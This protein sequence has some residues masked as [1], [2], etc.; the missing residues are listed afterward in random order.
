MKNT[1]RAVAPLLVSLVLMPSA[2]SAQDFGL[3]DVLAR[4]SSYVE[5]FRTRLAGIVAEEKYVQD[6]QSNSDILVSSVRAMPHR[7]LKSDLLLVRPAETDMYLEFRDVFE[8][9]GKPVR[10]RQE[11]LSK[12]FLDPS[13][14][15]SDQI[16][17]IMTASAR[18][19]IGNI[20]RNINTPTLALLFLYR[21]FQPRFAFRRASDTLPALA[22]NQAREAETDRHFVVPRNAFVVEYREVRKGTVIRRITGGGDQPSRGRFWIEPETGRVLLSELIVEDPTVRCTIDVSYASEPVGGLL[23]PIEMRERYVN[24]RDKSVTTGTAV[25][26]NFRQ[27]KVSVD[28]V[29]QD[30]PRKE[31]R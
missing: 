6:A 3:T 22:R 28:E 4:A 26:G 15:A 25:Y 12:L 13:K 8:V 18:Y 19:N 29:I 27:F 16:D 7:E 23:T 1:R 17:Q 2:A 21:D 11:R 10:D 30:P 24:M 9:D 14:S 31:L 20:Y 5:Q